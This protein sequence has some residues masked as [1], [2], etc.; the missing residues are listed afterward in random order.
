[1]IKKIDPHHFD[2]KVFSLINNDWF[3]I[4][5]GDQNACNTMTASYGSLGILFGVPVAHIYVRPERHTYGFLENNQTFSL[6]FFAEEYRSKLQYCG[7][8][9]GR[10]ENKIDHCNFHLCFAEDGTPYYEE[11]RL[12]ILCEKIY[13]QDLDANLLNDPVLRQKVYGSGSVHR[14]Y[15]GKIKRIFETIK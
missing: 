2:E 1:M 5:A 8:T 13:V 6:S 12:T 14:M 4:T 9:S 11:A 10:N 15:I 7:R 3:L